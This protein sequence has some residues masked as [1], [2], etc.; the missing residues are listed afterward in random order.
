[1]IA[2]GE[3][4][5]DDSNPVNVASNRLSVDGSYIT[6]RSKLLEKKGLIRRKRS[7]IDARVVQMLLAQCDEA[8]REA[9]RAARR[10]RQVCLWSNQHAPPL[11]TETAAELFSGNKK[12]PKARGA[13]G[14]VYGAAT[15]RRK[16]KKA[17][18]FVGFS[19]FVVYF[20]G[21]YALGASTIQELSGSASRGEA[22]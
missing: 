1:M 12:W 8:T 20:H 11:L 7:K 18:Q 15:R 14:M 5:R 6:N 3:L 16:R 9:F 19:A 10:H 17:S 2:L 13:P 4:D 21:F 22:S